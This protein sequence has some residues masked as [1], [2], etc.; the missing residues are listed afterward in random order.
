MPKKKTKAKKQVTTVKRPSNSNVLH[1]TAE[2]L[3]NII[4]NAL[5]Q[6]EEQRKQIEE[7][8]KEQEKQKWR[9]EIGYKDY[10][11]SKSRFTEFLRVLNTVKCNFKLMF[12]PSEKIRGYRNISASLSDELSNNYFFAALISFMLSL[13]ILGLTVAWIIFNSVP[14]YIDLLLGFLSLCLFFFGLKN[15][16]AYHEVTYIKDDNLILNILA[17]HNSKTSITISIL[18]VLIA[19]FALFKDVIV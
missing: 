2:E 1:I 16:L 11:K 3:Q 6:A 12:M 9:E 10:S 15:R 14:W 7:D 8:K 4:T 19:V 13:L 17:S 18:S 5:L